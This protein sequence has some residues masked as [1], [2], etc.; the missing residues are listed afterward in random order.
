VRL[1]RVRRDDPDL[2]AR[3]VG[4]ARDHLSRRRPGNP[5]ARFHGR[6]LEDLAW[7]R[8]GDLDTFHAYAFGTCRQ[9]GATAELAA[10][11]V[12]WLAAHGEAG[13][14]PAADA[15]RR[16][17]SGAKSLQFVLARAVRGKDVD[18]EGPFADMEPAWAEATE[19]LAG[20]YGT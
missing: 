3:A 1:D 5:V 14:Q 20:R 9:C 18:V 11:F 10:S 4:L 12:D 19:L 8:S 2:V 7:L 15:F 17:A 16:V 13:V 6:V